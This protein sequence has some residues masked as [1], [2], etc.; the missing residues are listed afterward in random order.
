M[1]KGTRYK[2]YLLLYEL[3]NHIE[4]KGKRLAYLIDTNLVDLLL[5]SLTKEEI[6]KVFVSFIIQKMWRSNYV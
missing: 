5:L 4:H 1:S 6:E 3:I 2:A